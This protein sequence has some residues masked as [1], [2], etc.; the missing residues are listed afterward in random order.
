M[1]YIT[2]ASGKHFD[3]IHPKEELLDQRDLAHALSMICRGNGHTRIFY[4]V[5]QHSIACAREAEARGYSKRLCLACLLHDASEAY[6]SDV[7][8]PIKKELKRY[9]EVEE[10]LQEMIWGYYLGQKLSLKERAMVFEIDDAMLSLEFH[11]IMP[12]ELGEAHQELVRKITC[13]EEVPGKVE[14]EFIRLMDEYLEAISQVQSFF[15]NL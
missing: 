7:T 9:L 10:N 11:Q 5:A 15:R 8:R 2:T 13:Q 12:E 4:S 3:P 14:E 6:L 1:S